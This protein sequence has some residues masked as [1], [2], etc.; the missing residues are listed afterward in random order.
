MRTP[1]EQRNKKL[2]CE[3]HREYEHVTRNCRELK[4]ALDKLAE[5][6][7]L[8]RYLKNPSNRRREEE[9]HNNTRTDACINVISGGLASGGSSNRAGKVHLRSL[10]GQVL[11]IGT[12]STN[13][14]TPRMIFGGEEVDRIIQVPHDDPLAVEMKVANSLVKRVLVDSGSS[15]NIITWD[16]LRQ[17]KYNRE[18]LSPI[19]QPLVGFGGQTVYPIGT[20]KLPIRLGEKGKGR[21]LPVIFLVVD[22][23]LP[24]N[25]IIGRPLLNKVKADISTYQLLLQFETDDGSVGKLYGDQHS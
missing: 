23:A 17:L 9:A 16:C 2:W 21:S 4:R 3:Y 15:A 10:N 12:S 11:E 14:K 13:A 7:K 24:Y 18:D 6:G 1:E 25:I 5:E 8:N 22:T 19:S 20:L